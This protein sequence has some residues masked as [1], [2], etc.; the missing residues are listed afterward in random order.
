MVRRTFGFSGRAR[1]PSPDPVNALLSLGYT[2]VYNEISSLLDGL[3]FD[4]YL[5]FFHQPR[6]G[7]AT[8]ASDLLEEFRAPPG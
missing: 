6:Y 8:L 1:H 7:H 5:G 3:G 2:L 4:P